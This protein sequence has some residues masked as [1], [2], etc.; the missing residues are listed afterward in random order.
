M[1]LVCVK[2]TTAVENVGL[3]EV[4]LMPLV[5]SSKVK[6][7][8]VVS[9]LSTRYFSTSASAAFR[10]W[11]KIGGCCVLDSV[12]FSSQCALRP[13]MVLT[14]ERSWLRFWDTVISLSFG[15]EN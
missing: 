14:R 6:A 2:M 12:G 10:R 11:S 8:E 4:R 13:K 1:P 7:E 5:Y 15:F 9:K 3:S